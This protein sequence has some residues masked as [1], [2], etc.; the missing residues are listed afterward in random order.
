MTPGHV[1]PSEQR[2]DVS[3]STKGRRLWPGVSHRCPTCWTDIPITRKQCHFCSRPPTEPTKV[4]LRCHESQPLSAFASK[5]RY[6]LCDT[7][8]W[9]AKMTPH[10]MRVS[11]SLANA[12]CRRSRRRWTTLRNAK[13]NPAGV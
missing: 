13:K 5:G 3:L 6:R 7:C 2:S 9:A 4:C 1:S 10:E 12:A 11:H 8:R